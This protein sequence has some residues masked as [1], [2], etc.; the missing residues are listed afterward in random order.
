MLTSIPPQAVSSFPKDSVGF[1]N[2]CILFT[3]VD[4]LHDSLLVHEYVAIKTQNMRQLH[5]CLLLRVEK[6]LV[7]DNYPLVLQPTLSL[8]LYLHPH[9]SCGRTKHYFITIYIFVL[10][11]V[12]VQFHLPSCPFMCFNQCYSQCMQIRFDTVTYIMCNH[13]YE[14]KR[15]EEHQTFLSAYLLCV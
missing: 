10:F 15:V 14:L 11:S 4:L 5:F 12:F 1:C 3:A 2:V 8:M 7:W 13:L 9:D 6:T